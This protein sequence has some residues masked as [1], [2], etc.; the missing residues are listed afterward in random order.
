MR[1]PALLLASLFLAACEV[2]PKFVENGDIDDAMAR[3]QYK[4]VCVGLTM[5]DDDTRTYAARKM[6]EITE[7][8]AVECVCEN[9]K[10]DKKG[11]DAAV[12]SGLRGTDRDDLAGCFTPLVEDANLPNRMEAVVALG[13][14]PAA[15]ARTTLGKVAAEVGAD[16]EA[17]GAAISAIG[18]DPTHTATL[19]TILTDDA[20][21]TVRA[22]AAKGL[23]GVKDEAVVAAMQTALSSDADGAVR[24]EALLGLK[25]AGADGIDELI[26]SAMMKDE[27]GEVRKRAISAYRGTKRKEAIACLRDRALAVEEDPSVRSALLSVIKSSPK[28]DA[29]KILCDAIPF[30]V[31]SYMKEE[32]PPKVSGADIIKAQNDRDWDNSYDCIGRAYRAG[33]YSCFGKL[34]IG[35]W[36]RQVG[37]SAYL[38]NCP[39]YENP[40]VTGG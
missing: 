6:K 7:P 28:K 35:H 19:L 32:L 37:G 20:D 23:H 40:D 4:T 1:R 26:C 2:P 15:S 11:W 8:I 16:A 5:K 24:G 21:P 22:A 3:K 38:P 18:G 27:S 30:W 39:G 9:I 17:R 34:Y 29:K 33:G 36:F 31:R 10:D 12:A 13:M 14:I 25:R